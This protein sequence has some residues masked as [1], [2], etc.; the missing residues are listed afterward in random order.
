MKKL[1]TQITKCTHYATLFGSLP[2]NSQRSASYIAFGDASGHGVSAVTYAVVMQES[3]VTQ[4][5]VAA[6]SRP[7]KQGLTIPCL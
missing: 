2:R 4:G 5:L 7:A 6:K 3:G 1:G